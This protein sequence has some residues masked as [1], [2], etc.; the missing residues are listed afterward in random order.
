MYFANY[1]FALT[2]LTALL[3]LLRNPYVAGFFT[4]LIAS[5]ANFVGLRFFVA[6][7]Y[8]SGSTDSGY[9]PHPIDWRFLPE[10]GLFLKDMCLDLGRAV[11]EPLSRLKPFRGL[12]LP[13]VGKD[14]ERVVAEA[15][16]LLIHIPKTGGTSISKQLYHRHMP[17]LPA[18]TLRERL[19]NRLH[20]YPSFAVMRHPVDRFMSAY[21]FTLQGGTDIILASRFERWR[22]SPMEPL[23]AFLDALHA[24]PKLMRM[25][26]QF[27]PQ[28]DFV[29]DREGH[30]MTDRL[31]AFTPQGQM[32]AALTDWL[33]LSSIPHI[34][35][36]HSHALSI[37]DRQRQ[38]ILEL[39]REDMDLYER[40]TATG[41]C[42]IAAQA[43]EHRVTSN[44]G[45]LGLKEAA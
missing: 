33:G 28:V 27:W 3:W 37:T 8:G 45:N 16:Y 31:F 43:A 4:I 7:P 10:W 30:L 23:D 5:A 15:G 18:A 11:V 12:W 25:A 21:R 35:A 26:P 22:L 36:T 32:P 1:L 24:N 9:R 39:Y 17:H 2:V 13:L 38:A 34:N 14:I 40:V 41:N 19:G 44:H 20:Q 29:V 6:S 42:L